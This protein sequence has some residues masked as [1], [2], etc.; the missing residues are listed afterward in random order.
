[1]FIPTIGIIALVAFF[2][3][4]EYR[5]GALQKR[6]EDLETEPDHKYQESMKILTDNGMDHIEA[7][8]IIEGYF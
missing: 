2:I 7:H 8:N 4:R 5:I 3:Q 1:M 6:I